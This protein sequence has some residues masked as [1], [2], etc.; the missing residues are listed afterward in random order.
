MERAV[1][2]SR[3]QIDGLD[4]ACLQSMHI[5]VKLMK[6]RDMLRTEFVFI[7]TIGQIASENVEMYQV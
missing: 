4:M 1:Q 3:N 2:R 5:C 6:S 7:S